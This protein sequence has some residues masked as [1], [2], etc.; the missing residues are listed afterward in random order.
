MN[1]SL[2]WWILV[3][4][5]SGLIFY[6]TKSPIFTGANTAD[7]IDRTTPILNSSV[8]TYA[9]VALRKFAHV[10][11]FGILASLLWNALQPARWSF[12][13]AWGLA[14][15]YAITDEWHQSFVPNRSALIQDVMLDSTGALLFLGII[16]LWQKRK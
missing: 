15:L 11:A 10:F 2:F 8:L 9:N 16:Y 3:I 14:T 12:A 1:R 13:I 7:L 5:W 6:F 4:L